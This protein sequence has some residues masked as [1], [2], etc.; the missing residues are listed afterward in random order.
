MTHITDDAYALSDWEGTDFSAGKVRAPGESG[1]I[2]M[3]WNMQNGDNGEVIITVSDAFSNGRATVVLDKANAT[4][5]LE[6][7]NTLLGNPFHN[8]ADGG[9]APSAD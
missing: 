9:M 6:H 5:V 1:G 7:L 8:V 4:E 3:G 2:Q